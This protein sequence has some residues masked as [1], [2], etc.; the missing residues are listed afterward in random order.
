ML[1]LA[2]SVNAHMIMRTPTPANSPDSSPLE[3]GGGDYPCK[4]K[5]DVSSGPVNTMHVGEAQTLSFTGS[6]VHGGGSCQVSIA[7]GTKVDASTKWMVIHSIEGGCP[8][9]AAGNLATDPN[10]TGA[11]TFQ[12]TI[13]NHPDIPTGK[14]TLAWTWHNKIGNREMYMNCALV[15]IQGAKKKRYAPANY[16]KRQS[17]PLPDMFKANIGNGCSTTEGID[18]QY[19]NPGSSL[20]VG[21]DAKLGPPVGNCGSSSGSASPGKGS[22]AAVPS[23]TTSAAKTAGASPAASSAISQSVGGGFATVTGSGSAPTAASSAAAQQP[24][25]AA[26]SAT[27]AAAPVGTG[28]S[29]TPST[30][31]PSTGASGSCNVGDW[32]CAADG[33]SFERC[34]AG[35]TWSASI[36]MP[37]GLSCTPGISANFVYNLTGGHAKRDLRNHVSRRH[38]N[39]PAAMVS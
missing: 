27:S 38:H 24:S 32:N 36:A 25:A 22:S 37:A 26:S 21:K 39:L 4:G 13:P 18:V 29:G 30:G 10:G 9:D 16:S 12:F 19:P 7:A 1:A 5:G 28:T 11:A 17:A 2:A 33:K 15:D 31:S 34:I 8:A 23:A 20:E 14:N 6:A 35:G 3:A